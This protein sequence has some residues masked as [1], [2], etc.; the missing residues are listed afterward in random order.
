MKLKKYT[1]SHR[2]EMENKKFSADEFGWENYSELCKNSVSV[3][4]AAEKMGVNKECIYKLLRNDIL[5]GQRVAGIWYID[6]ANFKQWLKDTGHTVTLTPGWYESGGSRR[7]ISE[8][9]YERE[10]KYLTPGGAT[11]YCS[12][13]EF[14]AWLKK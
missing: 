14:A 10:V 1:T 13:Q 7:Y 8:I 3:M 4:Y 11:R 2:T 12:V 5:I 9:R 6:E